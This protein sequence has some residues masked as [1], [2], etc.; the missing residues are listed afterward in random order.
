VSRDLKAD[1]AMVQVADTRLGLGQLAAH[2]RRQFQIPVIAVTGSNGKTTVK[3]MIAAI[4]NVVGPTLATQGNLNNDIGVPLTLL[5]LRQGDR[6]AVIEMG[7]NHPGEIDYLTKLACPTI[8]LINNAAAAHLAGLGSV[9]AVARAK[10]EIYAGLAADGIAVINA[11]DAYAD[12]WR[13]LAAPHRIITFGLDRTADV[14][15]EFQLDAGGS[16]IHLKTPHGGISMRLS[17]LGRHN[18][19]NALAASSA[20]LAAGVSLADIQAGLEKLRSVT[21]RLEVKRGL[22]GARVLDDTYNANPGSLAAGVEVLKAASGERVLVLGDMGEL[23]DAARD[24]HRR[25]GLLAKSLGIEQLYAVGELTQEAVE[26][27]GKGAQHFTSHE[28]LIETLRACLHAGMTVLVKGSRLMKMERV[29]AGI[30]A[31]DSNGGKA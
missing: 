5:R 8:A 14:S 31:D 26:A 6:H 1:I 7:M 2:W 9:E 3:N 25:V 15:A 11:D 23:G 30:V 20:T 19:M 24:I 22:N 4:L 13:E 27:F 28:A 16:T 18:V 21:G 10:G 17:L 29:V 12:L